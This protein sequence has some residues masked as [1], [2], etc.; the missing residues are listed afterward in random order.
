MV[1]Q[2][3]FDP[4]MGFGNSGLPADQAVILAFNSGQVLDL[5]VGSEAPRRN[6]NVL[7]YVPVGIGISGEVTFTSDLLRS[8]VIESEAQFF[9]KDRTFLNMGQGSATI[10]YRPIP[11]EGQFHVSEIRLNLGQG[12]MPVLG[13]GKEIEPLDKIPEVCLDA[14]NSTPEGCIPRRQ[15]FLPEIEVFDRT[16]EGAWVRLPRLAG[17]QQYELVNPTR[18]VDPT[19]GQVLV[20]FVNESLEMSVGFAFQLALLGTIA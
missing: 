2:L 6:G 3:T 1:Q 18:Y 19:T 8:T 14:T 5:Q 15:D 20:R 10:A 11:F 12:G 7:Y 4:N 17:D 16:G 9:S 13:G